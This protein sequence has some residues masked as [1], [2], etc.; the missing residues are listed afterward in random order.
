MIKLSCTGCG[1][2]L[3]VPDDA[4]GKTGRCPSCKTSVVVP[5]A[6]S[7]ALDVA[8]APP[9]SASPIPPPMQSPPPTPPIHTG[10][11]SLGVASL[12]LGALAFAICW[13]PLLGVFGL[14]LS[15]L[16]LILGGIGLLVAVRRSGRGVGFSIAGTA[17]SLLALTVS[18]GV[19]V[20]FGRVVH[21]TG[22]A[23]SDARERQEATNQTVVGAGQ[24]GKAPEEN[25]EPNLPEPGNKD[26]DKWAS[27]KEVVQ[28]GD[29]RIRI[30]AL[31]I[32]KIPLKNLGRFTQSEDDLL[33]VNV[34]VLNT[35]AT[36]K[37][38]YETWRGKPFS[39]DRDTATM[40]DNF[41]N[42]LKRINFGFGTEVDGAVD[43]AES[44]YPGKLLSD[45]LVFE[46]P[47][48]GSEW[49]RLE[50]P[51]QNFGGSGNIR[52]EIPSDMFKP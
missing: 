30:N 21:E 38:N 25:N 2:K 11:N 8:A 51:A 9:P 39:I 36:K 27:A 50:L 49:L 18:I 12:I 41:G 15:G 29:I 28:Q 16:G 45:I 10:S 22:R 44:I 42:T 33:A 31:A 4:A 14:P 43:G 1:R 35:S 48:D 32:Q 5:P 47:I 7:R 52:F 37:A 3:N 46:A 40:T 20:L 19:T 13:I 24:E 26:S 34:E 6:P 17:L 23:M